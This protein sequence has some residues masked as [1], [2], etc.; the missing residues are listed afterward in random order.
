SATADWLRMFAE[1]LARKTS[2]PQ[3]EGTLCFEI[4]LDIGSSWSSA[5]GCDYVGGTAKPHRQR[6]HSVATLTAPAVS[7]SINCKRLWGRRHIHA[8]RRRCV[9][10]GIPQCRADVRGA[11]ANGLSVAFFLFCPPRRS[12]G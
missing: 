6:L 12:I 7:Q 11:H 4:D 10:D 2:C 3:S 1:K 9:V 5:R 8:E